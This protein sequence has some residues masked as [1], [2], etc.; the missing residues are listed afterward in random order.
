METIIE[1]CKAG[2]I[3]ECAKL[4]AG[5]ENRDV[6]FIV[7]EIADGRI[8]VLKR[9]L[10]AHGKKETRTEETMTEE[11]MTEETM[12]EETMTEETMTEETMTEETMTEE[13]MTEETKFVGIGYG[14]RTKLNVNLGTSSIGE[15]SEEVEKAKIADK[16][17]ADAIT[18][19]S[20]CGDISKIREGIFECTTMPVITCPIYQ[21]VAEN[22]NNGNGFKF[23]G[24][25][26][27]SNIKRHLSEGVSAV[28]LHLS[29]TKD[30]IKGLKS[31]KRIDGVVSKGGALTA[32][33]M[34]ENK[35]ENPFIE[36]FTE[37]LEILH[38]YD[39]TLIL[40]NVMR[41]GGVCDEMDELHINEMKINRNF[42]NKAH[43]HGVQVIV[44][45]LG[46]HIAAKNLISYTKFYRKNIK[47]PIFASGPVPV[48]CAL[49]YDHIAASLG[50]GIVAGHGADFLCCITP[51]EHLALPSVEDVKEGII[52]F[53]ITAEFADAMKYGIS[54]KDRAM[55]EA[56]NGHNWEKQFNLAIDG[57][58]RARQ[59]GKNLIKGIGCTMCGKYCAVDVM[60]K[61]M[62]KIVTSQ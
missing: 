29:M 57:G 25:E 8:V 1:Q 38:D 33:Y 28:V 12:T 58:E 62:D 35:C 9:N 40:G 47:F 42:A 18:E 26:I 6:H 55:D 34:I 15:I 20:M 4:I 3:P 17:K 21:V 37:I 48:E 30:A 14:L 2:K 51:A 44:E 7:K 36:N 45:A 59:K 52:T 23:N 22:F 5:S 19:M 11:T 27:L 39:A 50:A 41:S 16:F 54:E 60:K 49:G 56:R 46:G 31:T 32:A 43:M 13:T 10:K 53:K 61:Y 24:M